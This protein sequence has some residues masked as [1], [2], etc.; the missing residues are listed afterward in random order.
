VR[1]EWEQQAPLLICGFDMS[2]HSAE[3]L[4]FRRPKVSAWL[5]PRLQQAGNIRIGKP[6]VCCRQWCLQSPTGMLDVPIAHWLI[7]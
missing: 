7:C 6:M 5:F 1:Q 3:A 4:L 2:R